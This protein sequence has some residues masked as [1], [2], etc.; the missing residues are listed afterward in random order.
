MLN[1]RKN[2]IVRAMVGVCIM[3]QIVAFM[4]HHHHSGSN[5]A[6]INFTHLLDHSDDLCEGHCD[7]DH[8]HAETPI[9]VCSSH[10]LVI[11]EPERQQIE[12]ILPE[13]PLPESGIDMQCF[14]DVLKIKETETL[15]IFRKYN[16]PS[17]WTIPL[18]NYICAAIPP[19]APDFTA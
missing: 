15:H 8:E 10:H 11:T 18:M 19:R 16:L 12:I 17:G 4:P 9:A 6:C 14:S 3:M 7:G 2:I 13:T 5:V 1:I